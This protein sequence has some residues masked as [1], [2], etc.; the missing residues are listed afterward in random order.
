MRLD[1][2]LSQLAGY[3]DG[4]GKWHGFPFYY[5]LVMLSETDRALSAD[6]LEYASPLF[7]RLSHQDWSNDRFSN[8]C[9]SILHKI[10]TRSE[11]DAYPLLLGQY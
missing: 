10:K 7:E 1:Q 3:R 4:K 8:R 11:Y 6:E 9:Q 2:F 5:T